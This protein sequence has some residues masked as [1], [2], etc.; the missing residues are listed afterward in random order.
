M[1]EL[2]LTLLGMYLGGWDDKDGRAAIYSSG[3][4]TYRTWMPD[5]AIAQDGGL[6]VAAKLDHHR[7]WANDDHATIQIFFDNTCKIVKVNS[8]IQIGDKVYNAEAVQ[9]GVIDAGGPYGEAIALGIEIC[10]QLYS[11]LTHETGGRAHFPAVIQLNILKIAQC[12]LPIVRWRRWE[13]CGGIL[14]S[15]PAVSSW[16]AGR[17][18]VF[19]VGADADRNLFHM[20]YDNAWYPWQP[21]G[22]GPNGHTITDLDVVS[23]Q[24]NRIDIFARINPVGM[25]GAIPPYISHKEWNG[26]S[27]TSWKGGVGNN[28]P[29]I[30]SGPAVS[31]WSEGRLDVFATNY[32]N[33]L[34]HTW[35]ENGKWN[36]W[37]TFQG[38]IRS[39]PCAVSWGYNRIDVFARGTDNTLVHKWFDGRWHDWESLGGHLTSSP[40]A[41]S[42]SEGRLDVFWKG[43]DAT[44][45]HIWFWN[46]WRSIESRGGI[47]TSAPTSVSWGSNRLDIFVR[48]KNYGMHHLCFG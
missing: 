2:D 23:T 8:T 12:V 33:E 30:A 20:C 24:Q 15:A 42:W 13:P 44:L 31:S 29:A 32:N 35:F 37:E 25:S 4:S 18:D 48:D 5:T 19:C 21:I 40:S 10:N 16:E 28:T 11:Q 39:A 14:L 36:E 6:Y 7:A 38:K 41:A 1:F 46:G 26:S 47:I 27:W 3:G 22:P 34:I 45:E 17:L 9:T 43:N